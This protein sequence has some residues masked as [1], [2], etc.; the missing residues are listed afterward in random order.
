MKIL[1]WSK[2]GGKKS[3]VWGLFLI[4]WKA[5]FSIVIL[6]FDN[7]TREAYHSHA[8]NA[9]SWVISG[10]LIENRIQGFIHDEQLID[11][12]VFTPSLK[13]VVTTRNNLHKVQSK[14]VTWVLSFRGSWVDHWYEV[15]EFGRPILMS[16]GR[17]EVRL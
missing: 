10:E 11:V 15:N 13:P 17:V 2:D 5:F 1:E 14:G 16:H 12:S 6:R 3:K 7:G 9:V 8:F 4:E